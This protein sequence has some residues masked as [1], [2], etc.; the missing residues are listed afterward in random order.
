MITKEKETEIRN[1]INSKE[2]T[3]FAERNI[4][5]KKNKKWNM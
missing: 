5:N 4:I 3:T 2:K 1:R